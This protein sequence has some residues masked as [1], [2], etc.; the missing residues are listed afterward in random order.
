ML[1]LLLVLLSLLATFSTLNAEIQ[2]E[3]DLDAATMRCDGTNLTIST[4]AVER[5]WTWSD[6][7]WTTSHLEV[8]PSGKSWQLAAENGEADWEIPGIDGPAELISV[9]ATQSTDEGFTTPH[10]EVISTI[11]YPESDFHLQHVVWA[12]PNAP[13]LRTQLRLRRGDSHVITDDPAPTIRVIKGEQ[14]ESNVTPDATIPSAFLSA[15]TDERAVEL[16]F[17]GL[18]PEKQYSLG[19]SWWNWEDVGREQC[20]VLANMDGTQF[21]TIIEKTP[22]PTWDSSQPDVGQ[23]IVELQPAIFSDGGVQAWIVLTDGANSTIS[24][25][26]L[27]EHDAETSLVEGIPADRMSD[28]TASAPDGAKLVAYLDCGS[29]DPG[30]TT[31][32]SDPQA[33]DIA[34]QI[35]IPLDGVEVTAVGYYGDT[36]RRNSRETELLKEEF[37]DSTPQTIDWANLITARQASASLTLVKESHKCVNTPNGGANTGAF[38]LAENGIEITGLGW[39]LEDVGSDRFHS[40]WANWLVMAEGDDDDVNLA[41]KV[42]DRIRYPIDPDHDIYIMANTWG[43]AENKRDAQIQAR[44]DNVLTEIDSQADLGVDVQQIDD[45]WQGFD[46]VNWHPVKSN[47]LDETDAA[48]SVYES[49]RYPVYPDG[50]K[51]VRDYAQEKDI[52]L[53]L[54]FS[55]TATTD[56]LIR[57][58]DEGGFEYFKIDFSWLGN[59]GA[60]ETMTAKARELILHSD[61]A[62]RINWDVTEISPRMGYFFGR[63]YGNIY[64]ENRLKNYVPY[65]VLRDAWHCARYLNLN[66]F[67]FT[68]ANVDHVEMEGS[69]AD[70]HP[71]DYCVAQTL[72]SSPILV[73]NTQH[74]TE[75]ARKLIRPLLA[76]YRAH[77]DEIYQGYVFPIGDKPDNRS[78]SGFQCVLPDQQ[79]GYLTVFRQL[80]NPESTQAIELKFV[81]AGSEITLTDLLSERSWTETVGE[82][83]QV[84]FEIDEAP[85]YQFLR[86]DVSTTFPDEEPRDS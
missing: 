51:T 48:Y 84:D 22:I 32:E 59:M 21:D 9:T 27:Y 42:W 81:K 23:Q 39:L 60:V 38:I 75:E 83:G 20:V 46:Y 61:H 43:S 76:A 16:R 73:Q 33:A 56:D 19:L 8:L 50:W 57:N 70:Q 13:G 15:A 86:Y 5:R 82:N 30:S 14:E 45:G 85:G 79:A 44:E 67:Q 64:V 37:V 24:E 2:R 52:R 6:R 10:L 12:Y 80:E 55:V 29:G 40:C 31:P 11:H 25:A 41:L 54:W 77:R 1:R 35:R 28:L 74:Y 68:A 3:A 26:W 18:N 65:L 36:Q 78:W 17:K 49:D 53:G 7:G 71:Q 62:A 63:E 69:D 47:A 66:K 58:Y 4:G 72:M 34:D